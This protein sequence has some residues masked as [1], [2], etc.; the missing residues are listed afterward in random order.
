V[1]DWH[2]KEI[3]NKDMLGVTLNQIKEY[4]DDN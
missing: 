1:V 4:F 2:R 3:Q